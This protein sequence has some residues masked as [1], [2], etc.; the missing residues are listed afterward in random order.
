MEKVV[1]YKLWYFEDCR[2]NEKY[3]FETKQ[4]A[5]V[6]RF[7]AYSSYDYERLTKRG[8]VVPV[9][10]VASILVSEKEIENIKINK[11]EMNSEMDAE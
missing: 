3:Y 5:E 9:T 10:A 1:F 8:F 7:C 2:K 6:A 11:V 4:E